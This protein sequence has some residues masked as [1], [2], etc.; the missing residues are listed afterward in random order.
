LHVASEDDEIDPEI[1]DQIAKLLFG[2]LTRVVGDWNVMKR[3]TVVGGHGGEGVVI[4]HNRDDLE[5]KITVVD[6]IENVEEAVVV[7]GDHDHDAVGVSKITNSKIGVET[8]E[9]SSER[10]EDVGET[11]IRF[12]VSSHRKQTGDGISELVVFEDVATEAHDGL[13]D[14][15]DNSRLVGALERSDEMCQGYVLTL[16]KV[17]CRTRGSSRG[18]YE[19]WAVDSRKQL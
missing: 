7:L 12:E 10:L 4:R 13:R 6:A 9:I 2:D 14:G 18:G 11:S 5:G 3:D 19:R 8:F 17:Q 16:G 15:E 1:D